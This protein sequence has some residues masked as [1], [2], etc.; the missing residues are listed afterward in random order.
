MD[1]RRLRPTD[2]HGG[3]IFA[4]QMLLVLAAAWLDEGER[5]T[6]ASVFAAAIAVSAVTVLLLGHRRSATFLAAL[7]GLA[8]AGILIDG[9]R[10]E[11]RL[12]GML[13]LAVVYAWAAS[14]SV[15]HAFAT[16]VAAAQRILCGA[17]GYVM[18]GFIFAV[19]HALVDGWRDGAYLL[20][21]GP[22]AVRTPRWLDFI[23]MSFSIL[24]TAGF[25]ELAPV[26]RWA[27]MLCTLEAIT[28]IL[29][30]ATLI[31]RIASLPSR[32]DAAA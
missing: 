10:L 12:P 27:S 23:W 5:H 15:R 11:I 26:D 7:S 21:A 18:I 8:V 32:P 20:P 3:L 2:H 4:G 19:L 16:D 25:A 6:P 17:A 24:T 31:A 29:F 28:G 14:L 30:P 13:V 1:P 9:E 22:E